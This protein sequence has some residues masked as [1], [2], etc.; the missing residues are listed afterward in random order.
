VTIVGELPQYRFR[1]PLAC[2]SHHLRAIPSAFVSNIL[3]QPCLHPLE[4]AA[5]VDRVL[6]ASRASNVKPN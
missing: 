4:I 3:A 1:S 6:S 2:F 5:G